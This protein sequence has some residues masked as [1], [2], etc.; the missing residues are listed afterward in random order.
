M[1]RSLLPGDC[2]PSSTQNKKGKKKGGERERKRERK[3]KTKRNE[4]GKER[5][6]KRYLGIILAHTTIFMSRN[7]ILREKTP[8]SNRRLALFTCNPQTGLVILVVQII[9][10]PVSISH[11]EHHDGAE[12]SHSLL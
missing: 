11:I 5:E 10:P 4:K 1:I 8:A 9:T 2:L 3:R 6:T 12:I 7:D